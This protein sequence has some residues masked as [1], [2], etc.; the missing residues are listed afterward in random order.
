MIITII[1]LQLSASRWWIG[2]SGL[3]PPFRFAFSLRACHTVYDLHNTPL[4]P[5]PLLQL[6]YT[7]RLPPFTILTRDPDR[8]P[9]TITF[10]RTPFGRASRLFAFCDS[11]FTSRR[12]AGPPNA[13]ICSQIVRPVRLTEQKGQREFK[14]LF[15][16][17]SIQFERPPKFIRRLVSQT[18]RLRSHGCNIFFTEFPKAGGYYWFALSHFLLTT[19]QR[20][21]KNIWRNLSEWGKNEPR[22]T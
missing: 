18:K 10:P 6:T 16:T 14:N 21:L 11:G 17:R 15:S 9:G 3:P 12:S 19:L 1:K 4:P 7:H 13:Y 5:T 20:H 22:I 2:T 8:T